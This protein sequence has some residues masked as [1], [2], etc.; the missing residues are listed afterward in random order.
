MG[1]W[2][3][4]GKYVLSQIVHF[5]NQ[6]NDLHRKHEE[7]VL[8]LEKDCSALYEHCEKCRKECELRRFITEVNQSIEEIRKKAEAIRTLKIFI[9]IGISNIVALW[10]AYAALFLLFHYHAAEK[11]KP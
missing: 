9:T 10:A 5:G 11:L 7:L 8:K 1:T 6:L 2:L 4:D 3:Q